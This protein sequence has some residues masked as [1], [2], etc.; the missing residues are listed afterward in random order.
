MP[1]H[2]FL[3]N[4]NYVQPPARI[5]KQLLP[6]KCKVPMSQHFSALHGVQVKAKVQMSEFT[7]EDR[8]WSSSHPSWYRTGNSG[9]LPFVTFPSWTA[10]RPESQAKKRTLP[11]ADSC[12]RGVKLS[13]LASENGYRR[14]R[15]MYRDRKEADAEVSEDC[16]RV[17]SSLRSTLPSIPSGFVE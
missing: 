7:F 16:V 6:G 8:T 11:Q 17:A 9:S 14:I 1:I 13:S 3:E 12:D 10:S 15:R 4:T 5:L 2:T